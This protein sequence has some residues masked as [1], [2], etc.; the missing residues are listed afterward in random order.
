MGI[1]PELD[2]ITTTPNFAPTRHF[3]IPIAHKNILNIE[4]SVSS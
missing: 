1:E 4:L 2:C 3:E